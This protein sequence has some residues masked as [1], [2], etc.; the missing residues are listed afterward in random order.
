MPL[1]DS[2]QFTSHP[3]SWEAFF[4][5][6]DIKPIFWQHGVKL[7]NHIDCGSI[8]RPQQAHEVDILLLLPDS[9][10]LSCH[11]KINNVSEAGLIQVTRSKT[12]GATHFEVKC[13]FRISASGPSVISIFAREAAASKESSLSQLLSFHVLAS[14]STSGSHVTVPK[15]PTSY[16]ETQNFS[17]ITPLI[18]PLPRQTVQ[19]FQIKDVSRTSHTNNHVFALWWEK[20]FEHNFTRKIVEG[21]VVYV[22]IRNVPETEMI[23]LGYKARSG[24]SNSYSALVQWKVQ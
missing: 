23:T 13:T 15:F 4:A 19:H 16:L 11:L 22:C 2:R 6:N 3:F 21:E 17:L 24:D 7:M 20:N 14:P 5:L 8:L 1:E 12:A 10:Q 9:L 18:S